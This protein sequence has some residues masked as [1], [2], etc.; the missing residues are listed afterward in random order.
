MCYKHVHR[1]TIHTS[2]KVETTSCSSTDEKIHIYIYGISIT[3]GYY[4]AIK[5]NK[6]LIHDKMWM[7]LENVKWKNLDPKTQIL[8]GSIY[9]RHSEY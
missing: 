1:S 5:A 9:I 2:Q 6:I 4:S 8:H 3:I 7:N